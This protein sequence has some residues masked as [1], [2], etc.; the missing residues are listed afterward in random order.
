MVSRGF[1]VARW[2]IVFVWGVGVLPILGL[3]VIATAASQLELSLFVR[4]LSSG[5]ALTA[6]IYLLMLAWRVAAHPLITVTR[7]EIHVARPFSGNSRPHVVDRRHLAGIDWC[8]RDRLTLRL[9]SGVA[10]EIDL[11]WLARPDRDHLFSLIGEHRH[12]RAV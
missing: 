7:A 4:T 3:A 11:R 10:L 9:A 8:Q 6:G 5:A 1:F 12:H 2:V